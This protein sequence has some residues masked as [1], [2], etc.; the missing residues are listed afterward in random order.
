M[1][2]LTE[3]QHWNVPEALT[4]VFQKKKK[5]DELK[6]SNWCFTFQTVM[7]VEKRHLTAASSPSLAPR[8]TEFSVSCQHSPVLGLA[9]Q[10]AT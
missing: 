9:P 5:I 6:E 3:A 8:G 1:F 2:K 10:N 7:K 4:S